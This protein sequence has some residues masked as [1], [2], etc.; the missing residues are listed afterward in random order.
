MQTL[1][2]QFD[3]GLHFN[4]RCVSSEHSVNALLSNGEQ[5]PVVFPVS[6]LQSSGWQLESSDRT[7][8]FE[9]DGD[10]YFALEFLLD[11]H[12]PQW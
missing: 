7:N 1:F 10:F 11:G 9:S 12:V 8:S 2:G 3:L 4:S 6:Q 5:S